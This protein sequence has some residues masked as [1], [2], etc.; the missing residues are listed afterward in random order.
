MKNESGTEQYPG[1]V[2]RGKKAVSV[3]MLRT[4][5][6]ASHVFEPGQSVLGT[7]QNLPHFTEIRQRQQFVANS[8]EKDM[9]GSNKY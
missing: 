5:R 4:L 1:R 8:E 9:I 6:G 7:P 2:H 3:F